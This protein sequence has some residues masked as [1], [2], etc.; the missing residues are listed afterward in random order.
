MATIRSLEEFQEVVSAN[1][2]GEF[3][4]RDA[5]SEAGHNTMEGISKDGSLEI[6]Y[7]INTGRFG[8]YLLG[9][10]RDIRGFGN[11]LEEAHQ[12]AINV[13]DGNY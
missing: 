9:H 5:N 1:V 8:V 2:S 11:D 10:E 6:L 7:S 3:D 4:F 12:A 13:R